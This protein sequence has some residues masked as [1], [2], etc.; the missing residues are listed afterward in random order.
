MAYFKM[1]N[2]KGGVNGRKITL[3]SLDDGY[4]PPK[5]VEQIRKLVEKEGV[6][7]IFNSLGTPSNSAI[8]KYL[9][10]KGVPQLFVATGADKW[11]DPK[12][13][14]W[15]MGWQPSYAHLRQV[16]PREQARRQAL[17]PLPERRLR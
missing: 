13:N 1:I 7:F 3:L 11:A 6:A 8:Q 10:Q 12:N 16:P 15:T 17:H 4:A 14:K 5:A 2:E 9:N